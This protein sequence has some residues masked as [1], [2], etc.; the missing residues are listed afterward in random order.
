MQSLV[1]FV[2]NILQT[3]GQMDGRTTGNGLLEIPYSLQFDGLKLSCE[4]IKGKYSVNLCFKM[5]S[6]MANGKVQLFKNLS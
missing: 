5:R 3:D 2:I 4:I 6:V 1:E